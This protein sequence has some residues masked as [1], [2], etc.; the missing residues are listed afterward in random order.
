MLN[1]RLNILLIVSILLYSIKSYSNGPIQVKNSCVNN[2][3]YFTSGLEENNII[4]Y[5]WDFG[6]ASFSFDKDPFHAFQENGIYRITLTVMLKNGGQESYQQDYEVYS[7]PLAFFSNHGDCSSSTFFMDESVSQNELTSWQW[8]NGNEQ[9]STENNLSHSFAPGDKQITLRVS[10]SKGCI[11]YAE[12][13]ISINPQPDLKLENNIVCTAINNPIKVSTSIDESSIQSM[14]YIIDDKTYNKDDMNEFKFN[15]EGSI[16]FI[17]KIE[18]EEGCVDSL[19][20]NIQVVSSPSVQYSLE[21]KEGCAPMNLEVEGL[22][23]ETDSWEWNINN[24]LISSSSTLDQTLEIP[25]AYNVSVKVTAENGCVYNSPDHTIIVYPS[26]ILST[27]FEKKI[28]N[29]KAIVSVY[30]G[31][32]L[33]TKTIDWGDGTIEEYT[34]SASHEY[35]DFSTYIVKNIAL[36]EWGCQDSMLYPIDF[37]SEQ[38]IIASTTMS[39]NGDGVNDDFKIYTEFSNDM[40]LIIVD[41]LGRTVYKSTN[42]N[43]GWNGIVGN[44]LGSTGIYI[45]QLRSVDLNQ[46]LYQGHFLLQR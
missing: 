43:E 28:I 39:P 13:F 19:Y 31:D 18:T 7:A 44:T 21:N 26:P 33:S 37:S 10:D 41:P 20:S 40:E 15:T 32:P 27:R 6:D 1:S 46:V 5:Y 35:D 30:S 3:I 8:Y 34:S 23:S 9:I 38:K 42:L 24:N 45:Y 29:N 16:N 36:N 22:S 12:K 25:G 14:L 2:L 4:S 11:D 17:A